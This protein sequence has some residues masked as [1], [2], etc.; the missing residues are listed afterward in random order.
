MVLFSGRPLVIPWLAEQADAVLAAWFLGNEAGNAI[1]DVVLGRTSPSGRTPMSW[2]R[3]IGQ[4][5]LFFGERPSGR[6]FNPERSFHQ[7][8]HGRAERAAVPV[9]P[10]AHLRSLYV[11]ELL[12]DTSDTSRENDTIEARVDVTNEGAYAAEETVFLFTHDKVASVTRP[13]L[14]L[15]G[16]GKVDLRPGETRTVRITVPGQR[17]ALSRAGPRAR[18]RAGE[19]EVLVG[20]CADRVQLLVQTA[21]PGKRLTACGATHPRFYILRHTICEP[22]WPEPVQ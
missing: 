8:V 11:G 4:V 22:V 21:P 20:P 5:P 15:K 17:V 12:G 13:L 2:P 16:V 19:V 6:P 3:A 14:E 7:Q 18:V 10:R 1:A 9:R